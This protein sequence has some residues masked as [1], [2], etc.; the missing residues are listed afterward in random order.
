MF[1]DANIYRGAA[2]HGDSIV[3]I[4]SARK[5][6]G[7]QVTDEVFEEA[8][9]RGKRL[10]GVIP[11]ATAVRFDQSNRELEID[12]QDQELVKLSVSRLK[13]LALL[14]DDQLSRLKVGFAGKGL[15]LDEADLHVSIQGLIAANNAHENH[16]VVIKPVRPERS[17]TLRMEQNR[18]SY[19]DVVKKSTL[20]DSRTQKVRQWT[21]VRG[22][23]GWAGPTASTHIG[24]K[25]ILTRL[26]T[27]VFAKKKTRSE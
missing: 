18:E 1:D 21:P 6:S 22:P 15:Y 4:V 25:S 26:P 16:V 9:A 13:D 17:S 11:Q 23:A 12:F 24:G 8:V 27:R 10:Y 20:T 14:S 19:S 3:K 2:T 5:G 7:R